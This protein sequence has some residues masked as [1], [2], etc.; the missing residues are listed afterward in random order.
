MVHFIQKGRTRQ[1]REEEFKRISLLARIIVNRISSTKVGIP[2]EEEEYEEE[3]DDD[4]SND[5]FWDD[6]DIQWQDGDVQHYW[7]STNPDQWSVKHIEDGSTE[8][9]PSVNLKGFKR[10]IPEAFLRTKPGDRIIFYESQPVNKVVATG[11]VTQGLHTE[12]YADM[13]K[14]VEGI[15]LKYSNPVNCVIWE[16]IA[17]IQDLQGSSPVMNMA[18]GSLF[19]LTEEEYDTILSLDEFHTCTLEDAPT[20]GTGSIPGI[21][22]KIQA[23]LTTTSDDDI[24][25]VSGHEPSFSRFRDKLNEIGRASCRERV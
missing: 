3:F 14:E 24:Y 2:D 20:Y 16:T 7:L 15:S 6:Q 21:P 18:H 5:E 11:E 25:T 1:E 10:R 9:Y 17:G 13:D 19:P 4:E 23:E 22:A 12:H 8:F